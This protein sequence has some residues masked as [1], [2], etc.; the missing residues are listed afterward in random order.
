[1]KT[2][3]FSEKE[4]LSVIQKMVNASQQTFKQDAVY[5]LLW[6][7]LIFAAAIIHILLLYAGIQQGYFVWP[8]VLV[9][10]FFGSFYYGW[11]EEREAESRSYIDRVSHFLWIGSI[12]PLAITLGLGIVH[13]WVYAY[14]IFM[15]IYGWGVFVSGKLF[16]FKPLVWGGIGAWIIGFATLFVAEQWLLPLLALAVLISY[17]IPGHLLKKA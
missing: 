3:Q 14:P 2:T 4:A 12:A 15:A 13:G 5:L 9:I 16:N 7:W 8:V 17:L 6:G 11:K 1:M 10:G